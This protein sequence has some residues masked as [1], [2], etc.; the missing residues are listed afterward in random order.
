MEAIINGELVIF[1][2]A[3]G[4]GSF[5]IELDCVEPFHRIMGDMADG[6]LIVLNFYPSQGIGTYNPHGTY[7]TRDG[8][9][10]D[11]VNNVGYNQDHFNWETQTH[12][13]E[14]GNL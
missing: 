2:F 9:Y 7:I 1:D 5:N 6:H 4:D 13:E 8:P 14:I 12:I 3:S 11:G 10:N